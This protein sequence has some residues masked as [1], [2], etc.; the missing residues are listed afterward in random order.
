MN[1]YI[2]AFGVVVVVVI[3]NALF[4]R[5]WGLYRIELQPNISE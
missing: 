5:G 4:M 2:F 3:I 1:A